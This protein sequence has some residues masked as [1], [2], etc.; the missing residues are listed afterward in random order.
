MFEEV[1]AV[2][3]IGILVGQVLRMWKVKP[4]LWQVS[5]IT[6]SALLFSMGLS[7][8][9]GRGALSQILPEAVGTSLLLGT[10]AAIAGAVVTFFIRGRRRD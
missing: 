10:T 6:A 9:L 4:R 3:V 5:A 2:F 7:I 1:L 8:G